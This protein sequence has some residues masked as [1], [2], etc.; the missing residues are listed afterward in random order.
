MSTRSG[1]SWSSV[2]LGETGFAVTRYLSA[3]G[4]QVRVVDSRAAPP[5]LEALRATHPDVPVE[6]ET[7]DV[8]WLAGASR[9]VLSP[10]LG[11]DI[12]RIRNGRH[13]AG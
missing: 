9:V 1:G 3:L 7:L 8:K 12:R 5:R 11:A 4:E 10:G 2:G 6:L 13:P